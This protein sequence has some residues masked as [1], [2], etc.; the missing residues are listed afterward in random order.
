MFLMSSLRCASNSETICLAVTSCDNPPCV[1]QLCSL[2]CF[3]VLQ[4]I[5]YLISQYATARNK[6]IYDLDSKWTCSAPV[7]A[8]AADTRLSLLVTCVY[9]VLVI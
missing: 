8:T 9:V 2:V 5:D 4:Q 7:M 3:P 1:T 6:V